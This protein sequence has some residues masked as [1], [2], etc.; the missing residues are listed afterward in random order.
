VSTDKLLEQF[1]AYDPNAPLT[2][3]SLHVRARKALKARYESKFTIDFEP[4]EGVNVRDYHFLWCDEDELDLKV[5]RD[6]VW[7][8]QRFLQAKRGEPTDEEIIHWYDAEKFDVEAK[9]YATS[10]RST[11]W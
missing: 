10:M 5:S 4:P 1:R 8:R 3:H 9:S 11:F 7:V 2:D 6:I